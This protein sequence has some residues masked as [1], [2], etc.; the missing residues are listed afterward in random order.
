MQSPERGRNVELMAERLSDQDRAEFEAARLWQHQVT[1]KRL[2]ELDAGKPGRGE[3]SEEEI[4]QI[5]DRAIAE[6]SGP[7]PVI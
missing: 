4:D 7:E 2:Q 5:F 1:L 6:A 3:V